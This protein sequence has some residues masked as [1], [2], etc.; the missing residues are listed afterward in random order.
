VV[1]SEQAKAQEYQEGATKELRFGSIKSPVSQRL[2]ESSSK[3]DAVCA[4]N[5]GHST[6]WRALKFGVLKN[7]ELIELEGDEECMS[8]YSKVDDQQAAIELWPLRKRVGS[9][10][11]MRKN[12]LISTPATLGVWTK[13][14]LQPEIQQPYPHVAGRFGTSTATA[15]PRLNLPSRAYYLR[16]DAKY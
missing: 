15:F 11:L 12:L 10:R 16:S 9:I 14:H 8:I 6:A 1:V 2:P 3:G 13:A 7:K 5:A 4:D